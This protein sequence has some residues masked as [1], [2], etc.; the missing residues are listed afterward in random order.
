[1]AYASSKGA[2]LIDRALFLPED[3]ANDP[4]RRQKA[5]IPE[6]VAFS[7]KSELGQH[8]LARAFES[9]APQGWVTGD[10][11]YG[12]NGK[13]RR[14]LETQGRPF[15]FAVASNVSCGV[16]WGR[17]SDVLA[18][19][20]EPDWHRISAGQGE[21]GP[22]WYDWARTTLNPNAPE[23][24]RRW[25]LFRRRITD[26]QIDFFLSAAPSDT[27]LE[28]MVRVA[29][30]RWAIESCFEQAKGE[31][32]LDQYEVRSW[33]GW[34]RHITL[35]MAALAFLSVMRSKEASKKGDSIIEGCRG[36]RM[37][38]FK[39]ARAQAEQQKKTH[40]VKPGASR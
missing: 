25:A 6:S 28:E 24:W 8:M 13:L 21:K 7:T 39:H 31:V 36:E 29:G 17:V 16:A 19:V 38:T 18:E 26:G 34:H 15:V 33:D 35:V 4:A 5:G 27:S 2:A 22:R 10:E 9:G 32:G 23:P 12:K 11:A 40:Q 30:M 14:W 1:M 37:T 3:W 20:S